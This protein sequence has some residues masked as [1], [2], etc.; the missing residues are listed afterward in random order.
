MIVKKSGQ[1]RRSRIWTIK[2]PNL[3][4]FSSEPATFRTD[5]SHRNP[6]INRFFLS[7]RSNF[8]EIFERVIVMPGQLAL[9]L[10][11][12]MLT[13]LFEMNRT[14]EL[15]RVLTLLEPNISQHNMKW[16]FLWTRRIVFWMKALR[17]ACNSINVTQYTSAQSFLFLSKVTCFD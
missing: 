1:K 8:C 9:C 14:E 13:E 10:Q 4:H 2:K 15:H 6:H 17:C 12:F 3:S 11:F 16:L 5:T 7:A